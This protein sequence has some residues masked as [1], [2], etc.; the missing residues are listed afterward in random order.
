MV[1]CLGA[2]ASLAEDPISGHHTAV[3]NHLIAVPGGCCL[4][5]DSSS[6][7]HACI[8]RT[9]MHASKYPY[10]FKNKNQK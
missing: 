10:T 3:H 4:P 8:W 1:Q 7:R 5:L 9:Y 6:T 2:L